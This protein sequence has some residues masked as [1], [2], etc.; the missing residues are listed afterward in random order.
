MDQR[1]RLYDEVTCPVWCQLTLS[2]PWALI[3]WLH[4]CPSSHIGQPQ[5]VASGSGQPN[6]RPSQTFSELSHNSHH[7]KYIQIN[8][9]QSQTHPLE[10]CWRFTW[11]GGNT[12]SS[13]GQWRVRSRD[14][15]RLWS[16]AHHETRGPGSLGTRRSRWG[17][18][19]PE[20]RDTLRQRTGT[21][22]GVWSGAWLRTE[23]LWPGT[24][25]E[26]PAEAQSPA[27]IA[28]LWL[29]PGSQDQDSDKIFQILL[30]T[31][32]CRF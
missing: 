21:E 15:R 19:S 8:T 12:T 30:S 6:I 32:I 27:S 13:G 31:Q 24:E 4:L 25:A 20:S 2:G 18:R 3:T 23:T 5:A 9:K 7:K 17:V 1:W 26:H 14:L 10:A 28:Q 11:S 22:A 16:P 29:H